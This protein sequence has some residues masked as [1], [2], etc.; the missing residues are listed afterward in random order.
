M[1]LSVPIRSPAGYAQPAL[2]L[3]L[4]RDAEQVAVRDGMVERS[5]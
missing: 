4:A 2:R 5:R 1:P 3:V